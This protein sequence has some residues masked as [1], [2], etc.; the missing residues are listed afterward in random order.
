MGRKEIRQ[1]QIINT[2]IERGGKVPSTPEL[3]ERFEVTERT[4]QNDLNDISNLIPDA[5]I[6]DI[7][8]MLI[9]RLRE[10]LPM[11][12]DLN[13]LRLAEFFMSKKSESKHE[14]SGPTSITVVFDSEMEA[15]KEDE[16]EVSIQAPQG[17]EELPP[18]PAQ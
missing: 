10:R 15:K 7:K 14:V 5:V 16:M 8:N 17:T 13:L 1:R 4:I 12:S 9:F 6:D 3:A 2:I 18:G 11:F